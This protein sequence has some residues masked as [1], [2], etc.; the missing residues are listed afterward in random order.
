M[1]GRDEKYTQYFGLQNL[2]EKENLGD[3]GIEGKIILEWMCE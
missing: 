2:K 1:R 3:L